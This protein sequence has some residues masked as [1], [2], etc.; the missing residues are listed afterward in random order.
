LARDT[1]PRSADRHEKVA[2]GILLR[3]SQ[4]TGNTPTLPTPIE[5][6]IEQTYGL[7]VVYEF[8]D[9]PGDSMIVGALVPQ[10]R[11]IIL[12]TAHED[13]L[14]EVIGPERFTLGHELAHWVYDAENPDQM[15]LDIDEQSQIFCYD[16]K[17]QGLSETSRIREINA[18][19][20][21]AALLL[22]ESLVRGADIE[23]TDAEIRRLAHEWGVSGQ[24]LT[25]RL[26]E[27]G[28]Y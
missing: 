28:I 27:L 22:P 10:N 6:I 19:K 16:R 17:S 11:R 5:M 4:I 21:A 2:T 23:P 12:N 8:I 15:A 1:Y 25:I 9:E 26:N 24:T 18:N 3:H 14:G 20:L 7:E 13:L